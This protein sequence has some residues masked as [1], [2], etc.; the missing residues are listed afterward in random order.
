MPNF[1]AEPCLR[2]I[3]DSPLDPVSQRHCPGAN[4]PAVQV[5]NTRAGAA[6]RPCSPPPPPMLDLV[7]FAFGER[8]A[9]VQRRHRLA[10]PRR[11]RA[12]GS[13]SSTTPYQRALDLRVI[14]RVLDGPRRPWA[15]GV[16]ASLHAVDELAV[17]RSAAAS[18]HGSVPRAGRRPA[19]A[20]R[21]PLWLAQRRA[22]AM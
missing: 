19:S 7:V 6:P 3:N 8:Q 22:T 9:Q 14:Q 13:S 4:P 18:G 20:A 5:P 16:S 12:R 21:R 2:R 15:H 11:P 10:G 17:V 1:Q